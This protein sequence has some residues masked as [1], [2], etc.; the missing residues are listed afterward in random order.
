MGWVKSIAREVWGLFVEDGSFAGAILAWAVL[1]G[2]GLP[3]G[4]G[5][6]LDRAGAV[7]GV[8]GNPDR[9]RGAVCA[10]SAVGGAPPPPPS[11]LPYT[12]GIKVLWRN[13]LAGDW[14][15][16]W[17]GLVFL[18]PDL[19]AASKVCGRVIR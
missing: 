2:V 12:P 5:G 18:G 1:A 10:K 7:R 3:R 16:A 19:W 14:S 11:T 13:G 4:T 17:S 9:E 6:A 8:G 15:G